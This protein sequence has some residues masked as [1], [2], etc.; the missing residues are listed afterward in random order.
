MACCNAVA[1][2]SSRRSDVYF[3]RCGRARARLFIDHHCVNVFIRVL[4]FQSVSTVKIF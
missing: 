1:V 3:R 4:N 2:R